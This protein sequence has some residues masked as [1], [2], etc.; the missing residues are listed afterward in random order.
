MPVLVG[1]GRAIMSS[2]ILASGDRI[3]VNRVPARPLNRGN[4]L[5][6]PVMESRCFRA[7]RRISSSQ[8]PQEGQ[9]ELSG[10]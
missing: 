4:T 2:E 3:Q 6:D 1:I 7:T 5:L 8:L 10:L 9:D